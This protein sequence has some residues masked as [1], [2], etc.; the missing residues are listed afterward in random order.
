[1]RRILL[2]LAILI[3]LPLGVLKIFG[4]GPSAIPA[5]PAVA[6]GITAKIA[7]SGYYLSGFSDE[8]N[9]ADIATYSPLTD[10]I[11]VDHSQEGR[12]EANLLGLGAAT[13]RYFPGLGCT[14]Q[15]P[16]MPDFATLK[17]ARPAR[18][19]SP[20]SGGEALDEKLQAETE[21]ILQEDLE[22]G[23]DT[24]ALLVV[25]DGKLVAEAYRD[26]IDADTP[27]LGWSMGKSISAILLGRMEALGMVDVAER[28]LFPAWSSDSRADIT[29][30]QLLQMSSGLAFTEVYWP[31]GDA[32]DMLF[33]APSASD[34]A[35]ESNLGHEP[36]A[37]FYYSS[38]TSNLLSRLTWERL[39][40]DSQALLEFFASEIAEPLGLDN[41]TFELDASGV[42]VG[43]SYIYG[44]GRDW[45]RMGQLMIADG[46]AG[47]ERLLP[48]GWVARAAAPNSSDNDPRYGYQFWLNGGG[49]A[50]RWENL[51]PDAYAMLG[52][53]GQVVMMLPSRNAVLVRLGWSAAEYDK[54]V[55]LGPLQNAL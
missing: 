33:N 15:Y 7:C 3:A 55:R 1:M 48:E 37:F 4:I 41:T 45:A 8:Q 27:L 30:E 53:R 13:A 46:V 5:T 31:G 50:L 32:A 52:N 51:D 16:G 10:F 54:S 35:L 26:G 29:L 28:D 38:G 40:G 11:S 49:E 44:T 6:A 12:I 20:W 18:P 43:S 36:G 39:G 9:L 24:R 47:A 22:L 14:L 42:F 25:R 17:P 19:A 2:V 34:I 21:R 23:L